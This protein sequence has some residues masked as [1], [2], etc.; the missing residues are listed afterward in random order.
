[1]GPL[2]VEAKEQGTEE[3]LVHASQYSMPPEN[4]AK[5]PRNTE[6]GFLVKSFTLL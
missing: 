5:R 3:P 6:Y 1:M 4:R 2:G